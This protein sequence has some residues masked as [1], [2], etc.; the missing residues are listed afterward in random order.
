MQ[1]RRDPQALV[2][3]AHDDSAAVLYNE[4]AL[5]Q[6]LDLAD[7]LAKASIVP[8]ALRGKPADILIVLLSGHELGLSPMQALRSV[9]VVSGK[10]VL[11]ADLVVALVQARTDVCEYFELIES[12]DRIATYETKRR[13]RKT[14]TRMSFTI[15]DAERAGLLKQPAWRAYPRP[16][17]RHRCASELAREVFPDIVLGLYVQEEL[18]DL[19]QSGSVIDVPVTVAPPPPPAPTKAPGPSSPQE[20]A[21]ESAPAAGAEPAPQHEKPATPA[22]SS[23]DDLT[24]FE[25]KVALCEEKIL[26]APSLEKLK[27]L[28]P[29]FAKEPKDVQKAIKATFD[30]RWKELAQN[31]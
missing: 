28:M 25:K 5:T 15:E 3:V 27:E 21:P 22:G 30:N 19:V 31:G 11:A 2:P 9:A 6:A 17:L 24:V 26:A 7:R 18:P 29:E 8:E 23:T 20:P 16:M 4:K 1:N 12:T 14:P 13:N 10:P